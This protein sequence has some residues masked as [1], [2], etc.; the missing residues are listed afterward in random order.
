MEALGPVLSAEDSPVFAAVLERILVRFGAEVYKAGD[1]AQAM[2]LA[3]ERRYNFVLLD[4]ELPDTTGFELIPKVRELQP[5]AAILMVTGTGGANAATKALTLGADGFVEKHHINA[6]S[7]AAAEFIYA[8]EMAQGHRRG[9]VAE[10]RMEELKEDFFSMVTHDLRSPAAMAVM[11]LKLFRK[12]Q[13]DNYVD[14]LERAVNR[15]MARIDKYLCFAKMDAGFLE[16]DKQEGDLCE[17]V[18]KLVEE[19]H[20]TAKEKGQTVTCDLPVSPRADSFDLERLTLVV[21]NLISNAVKYAPEDSG[22]VTVVVRQEPESTVVEVSDNGKGITPENQPALF[23]RYYR[24]PG[25]TSRTPGTGLGLQIVSMVTE[26]HGGTI[27]VQSEG[28]PGQGATFRIELPY[29]P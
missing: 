3:K 18:R 10:Q 2:S 11:S 26:A 1:G 25:Q 5:D 15:L 7:E 8:L 28:V 16:L 23:D 27:S 29:S 6:A 4:L 9:K 13:A 19:F 17:V 21:E 12:T 24:A 14:L 20:A 22:V